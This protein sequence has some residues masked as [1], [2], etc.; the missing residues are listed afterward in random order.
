M[1]QRV[2]YFIRERVVT[3]T[4]RCLSP[5]G[6]TVCHQVLQVRRQGRHGC[7]GR[8]VQGPRFQ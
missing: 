6:T 8:R 2:P 7:L 1:D 4:D 5:G 3:V